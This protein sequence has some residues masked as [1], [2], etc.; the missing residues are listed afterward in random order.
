MARTP[1]AVDR[2]KFEAA[3]VNAEANGPLKNLGLLYGAIVKHYTIL[4]IDDNELKPISAAIAK[5]R[6]SE[7]QIEVKTD[8]G[9]KSKPN[10]FAIKITGILAG[11]ACIK[12]EVPAELTNIHEL[13]DELV[14]I[15]NEPLE[16][17]EST[18]PPADVADEETVEPIIPTAEVAAEVT[19]L[20]EVSD[21]NLAA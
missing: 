11:I 3:V 1:V 15:V 6:L 16:P 13:L 8:A 19:A 17:A 7:W 9:R 20:A 4:T 18:V 2:A 5:D 10:L 14:G 21:A 12:G